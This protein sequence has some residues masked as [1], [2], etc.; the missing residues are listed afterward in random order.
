MALKIQTKRNACAPVCSYRIG[1]VYRPI[2]SRKV[3]LKHT[4]MSSLSAKIYLML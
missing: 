3:E 4:G 1:S 2:G